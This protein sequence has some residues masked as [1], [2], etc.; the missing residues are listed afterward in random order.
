MEPKS[1]RNRRNRKPDNI[2]SIINLSNYKLKLYETKLLSRGL[3]FVPTFRPD[4]LE[5][6]KDNLIFQRRLKLIH[7][8]R[9]MDNQNRVQEPFKTSSGWT[10]PGI[11]PL[12]LN[13]YCVNTETKISKTISKTF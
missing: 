7:Y 3:K 2:T 11:F 5:I 8:F 1:Q 9:E 10:P 6:Q 13:C 4:P 12:H